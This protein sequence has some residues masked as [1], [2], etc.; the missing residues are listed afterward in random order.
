MRRF[1]NT[2]CHGSL[3][4]KLPAEL[5]A[6]P[7]SSRKPPLECTVLPLYCDCSTVYSS[8]R[9]DRQQMHCIAIAVHC[10]AGYGLGLV[11]LGPKMTPRTWRRK[12]RH[13]EVHFSHAHTSPQKPTGRLFQ[14]DFIRDCAGHN[15]SEK[16][17]KIGDLVNT[18]LPHSLSHVEYYRCDPWPQT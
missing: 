6:W 5:A 4:E 1:P 15:L 14:G 9:G 3:G 17:P 13:A 16:S 8:G 18:K 12:M 10:T 11:H 7:R 2:T